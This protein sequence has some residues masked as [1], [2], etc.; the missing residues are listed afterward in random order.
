MSCGSEKEEVSQEDTSS[1]R[2]ELDSTRN[3]VVVFLIP[4]M[5][6][7]IFSLLLNDNNAIHISKFNQL[8]SHSVG[9]YFESYSDYKA[10]LNAIYSGK[11][12]LLNAFNYDKDSVILNSWWDIFQPEHYH[13]S[14]ISNGS[15]GDYAIAAIHP[16]KYQSTHEAENTT[17]NL[18]KKKPDFIWGKGIQL[19]RYRKDNMDLFKELGVNDYDLNF[20]ISNK[21][22]SPKKVKYAGVFRDFQY[23]DSVDLIL[24]GIE[25]WAK[26]KN[27][28]KKN[29][30]L[31][32]VIND[33]KDR[34]SSSDSD[35]IYR[36]NNQIDFVFNSIGPDI[37]NTSIIII[38]PF[39]SHEWKVNYISNDSL[40]VRGMRNALNYSNNEVWSYN[41]PPGLFS[42]NF[43]NTDF[44]SKFSK[45]K[46]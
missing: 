40:N 9:S 4:G 32:V 36:I 34:L 33:L 41:T 15:L 30:A 6:N 22:V 26:Q 7:N 37:E 11:T 44:Y 3:N 29:F 43:K 39:Q 31:T 42:G 18:I 20:D 24:D 27:R 13:K 2:Q 10:N 28:S 19:F 21:E 38:N 23:P 8:G 46:H 16:G 1:A 17:L 35:L 14:I 25:V 45:I 5:D 12:T